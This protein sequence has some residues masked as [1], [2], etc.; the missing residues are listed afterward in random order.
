MRQRGAGTDSRL[1]R[2]EEDI[3]TRI[4]WLYYKEKLTQQQIS[5]RVS[6]SRQKVQR[7][8][9][10]AR[11]Q[12][13]IQ[14]ALKHPFV[15]LMSIETDLRERYGLQF[16]ADLYDVFNQRDYA[17]APASIFGVTSNA[18]STSYA[19]VNSPLFLNAKQFDGGSRIVQFGLKVT[20]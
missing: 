17:F 16:R 7:L 14:F 10:K 15:N 12:E 18:K 2:T 11:D 9:E 19:T 1:Y 8:L 4:A 20:F 3:I 5:E 13:I 6:L